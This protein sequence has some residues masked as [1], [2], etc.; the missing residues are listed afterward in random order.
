MGSEKS[1]LF[2]QFDISP[3]CRVPYLLTWLGPP[4]FRLLLRWTYKYFV[5]DQIITSKVK[6]VENYHSTLQSH[7]ASKTPSAAES[8]PQCQTFTPVYP[9]LRS[10]AKRLILR[11]HERFLTNDHVCLMCNEGNCLLLIN[12]CAIATSRS[13]IMLIYTTCGPQVAKYSAIA[14][15]SILTLWPFSYI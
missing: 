10:R 1:I 2:K 9:A 5:M 4:R 6:V 12:V 14:I 13:D 15:K 11:F 7:T 8:A 3:E